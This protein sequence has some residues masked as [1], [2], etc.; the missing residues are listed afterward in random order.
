M[1]GDAAGLYGEL[2]HVPCLVRTPGAIGPPPRSSAL[3]QPV[4]LP[5]TLLDWFGVAAADSTEPGLSLLA[6]DREGP[7]ACRQYVVAT[8][9]DGGR[10]IRTPAWMLYQRPPGAMQQEDQ[11]SAGVVELYLKP[12]DRWEANEIADR[13]PE[14]AAQLLAALDRVTATPDAKTQAI[15]EPLD[16]QLVSHPR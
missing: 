7:S 1:G 3:S 6:R 11:P 2:L 15:G 10:A 13:C 5:A 8:G 4:D 14:I 12:D 9:D 16:E